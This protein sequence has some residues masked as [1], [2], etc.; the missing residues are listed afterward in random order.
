MTLLRTTLAHEKETT[1]TSKRPP[2]ATHPPPSADAILLSF[3]CSV[4]NRAVN[5][6]LSAPT[7]P[8]GRASGRPLDVPTRRTLE[9]HFGQDFSSVRIHT[10]SKADASAL[11]LGAKAYTM[12]SNVVFRDGQYAPETEEGKRLLA[13]EMAHF[14]QQNR[15]T[16]HHGEETD[17][18]GDA[19]ELAADRAAA[20]VSM[21]QRTEVDVPGAPPALQ[22]QLL[23]PAAG[24]PTV[25]SL[26]AKPQIPSSLPT[27]DPHIGGPYG[28]NPPKQYTETDALQKALQAAVE[29][30]RKTEIGQQLEKSI[31]EYVLSKEGIPLIALVAA[32]AI[33]FVA[34]NDPRLPSVPEIELGQGIKLK[35]EYSGRISELPPLL[36]QM[37]GQSVH[38]DPHASERKIGLQLTVNNDQMMAAFKAVGH[39][40]YVVGRAIGQGLVTAGTVI[41]KV[42]KTIWPELAAMAGGALIGAG[43]GA[44]FGGGLGALIGA[45]IGAG[46]GLIGSLAR[47]LFT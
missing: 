42:A 46:V 16:G 24:N 17:R 1:S 2:E 7:V 40:F 31:K 47:R 37:V 26:A 4:G 36:R 8:R 15:S 38:T 20:A 25:P 21:G 44:L 32:C 14:V 10:G 22:R 12:G 34:A 29:E 30:F 35:F 28:S 5:H 27:N 45:G 11:S 18:P 39:F 19:F 13:H 33:T 23:T 9:G 41:G 43:I 3:Q 6:L